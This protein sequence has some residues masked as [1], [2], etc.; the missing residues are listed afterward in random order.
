[1]VDELYIK[2]AFKKC[3]GR[4]DQTVPNAKRPNTVKA[5]FNGMKYSV[6]SSIRGGS[7]NLDDIIGYHFCLF[8]ALIGIF[9]PE[10]CAPIEYE[11]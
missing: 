11:A 6:V 5:I 9:A 1:M 7:K 2:W 3:I 10:L 8:Y 4:G